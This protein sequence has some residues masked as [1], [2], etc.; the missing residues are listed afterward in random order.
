MSD[1]NQTIGYIRVSTVDQKIERQLHDMQLDKTFIDRVSGKTIDRPALKE[2]LNYARA[3]DVVV[4]H[5]MDRLARNTEDLLYLVNYLNRNN[6]S[7]RFIS[8]NLTFDGSNNPIGKLM[9]TIMGAIAQFEL[10]LMNER[11]REGIARA[12]AEGKFKGRPTNATKLSNVQKAYLERSIKYGVS[13][14]KIA[15]ELNI[16]RQTIYNYLKTQNKSDH[17]VDVHDMV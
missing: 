6:I 1:K 10:S 17:I 2:M 8:E 14:A 11:R 16:T 7:I 4:V 9:L 3:G 5:S 15:K 13:K 12:K